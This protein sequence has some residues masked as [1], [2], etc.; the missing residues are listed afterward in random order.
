M[1]ETYYGIIKKATVKVQASHIY[2]YNIYVLTY[3]CDYTEE[4]WEEN[5]HRI[6][7]DGCK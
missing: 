7:T 5:S 4:R 2:I 1:L 6:G 3:D